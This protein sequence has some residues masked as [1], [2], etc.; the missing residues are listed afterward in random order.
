MPIA[1]SNSSLRLYVCTDLIWTGPGKRTQKR[2][3]VPSG[4]Y[5]RCGVRADTHR[6]NVGAG[7][8]KI[9]SL[10]SQLRQSPVDCQQ[11]SLLLLLPSRLPISCI[12]QVSV[13]LCLSSTSLKVAQELF[14]KLKATLNTFSLPTFCHSL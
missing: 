11:I 6:S 10:A 5:K 12:S 7:C 8:R 2:F 4:L 13:F 3:Y 1:L 9:H 14:N